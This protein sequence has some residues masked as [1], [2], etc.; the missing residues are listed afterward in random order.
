M[1]QHAMISIKPEFASSIL[2]GMKTI[3][4][5]R[6][7]PDMPIG[8]K[9]WIY[10]TLPVG[11]IIAVVTLD[12]INRDSPE[13]LWLKYS[14]KAQIKL[15]EFNAY[16]LGCTSGIALDLSNVKTVKPIDLQSIRKIRGVKSIPQIA[17]RITEE[18]A[19]AF[20]NQKSY[21]QN[22]ALSDY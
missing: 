1:T 18:Q 12:S 17:V 13:N 20:S 11:A 5:R 3:E 22:T 8:S 14:E 10:S 7:F 9:L 2:S 19:Q 15:S 6:R 4:L 21:P 16:F